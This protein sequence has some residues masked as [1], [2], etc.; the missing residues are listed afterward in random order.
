MINITNLVW[1][2]FSMLM[3]FDYQTICFKLN[4]IRLIIY[5]IK[6]IIITFNNF[7]LLTYQILKLKLIIKYLF[8][9]SFQKLKPKAILFALFNSISNANLIIYDLAI[10][11]SKL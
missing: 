7:I 1:F 2:W 11:L 5:L 8:T 6:L 3:W 10:A 9:L 4:Q